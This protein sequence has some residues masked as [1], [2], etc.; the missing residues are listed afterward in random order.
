[1]S[2]APR[3]RQSTSQAADTIASALGMQISLLGHEEKQTAAPEVTFGAILAE[4]FLEFSVLSK[5][6]GPD[7]LPPISTLTRHP[8]LGAGKSFIARKVPATIYSHHS[9]KLRGKDYVVFKSLRHRER[10]DG[11][12]PSSR[13]VDERVPRL[14]NFLRELHVLMH[15]PLRKHDNIIGFIAVGWERNRLSRDSVF[16]W[17]FLVL[18]HA[19]YGSLVELL[20]DHPIDFETR[21]RLCLDVGLGLQALHA[22]DMIHG[23]IKPENVLVSGHAT[24]KYIAKIADFGFSIF[25]LEGT[26]PSIRQIGWTAPWQAPESGRSLVFADGKLTDVYSY[27]F[28][29]WRTVSYGHHPFHQRNG[30]PS[31]GCTE[32]IER[33]KQNDG[34]PEFAA[35][36]LKGFLNRPLLTFV[37]SALMKSAQ[38]SPRAR[39]LDQCLALLRY[40]FFLLSSMIMLTSLVPLLSHGRAPRRSPFEQRKFL[41]RYVAPSLTPHQ[42]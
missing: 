21:R 16:Y 41:W 32:D 22:C 18:E 17:P 29:L 3:A 38:F 25:D 1:M 34:I 20:E 8:V 23:D 10:I 42:N 30:M 14:Q 37:T 6:D 9:A 5:Q 35:S 15:N 27:G 24:R 12:E 7:R 36:S 2:F 28:L 13:H 33:A 11:H 40:I 31:A 26:S 39:N 19:E 4:V